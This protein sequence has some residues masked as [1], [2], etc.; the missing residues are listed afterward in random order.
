MKVKWQN[1]VFSGALQLTIF[2]TVIIAL[3][4]TG[5]VLLV[6][7]HLFFIEQSRS[8]IDTVQLADTG[9]ATLKQQE[10]ESIDTLSFA[11]AQV[12]E[13]QLI[14]THLSHWGVFEKAWVG[15]SHRNKEFIKC[16]LLGTVLASG[17]RPS[18]YLC[19]THKPLAVVGT[20]RIT[21][22]AFLPSLGIKTGSIAGHSYYGQVLIN[23]AIQSSGEALPELKHDYKRLL[24]FYLEEF[25]PENDRF[26]SLE[27][28]TMVINSFKEKVK[29]Y[30]SPKAVVLDNLTLKG[31]I[32]IRSDT[33]ITV[34]RTASL[35]DVLL[36][37]PT[38]IIEEGVRGNFQALAQTSIQTGKN[39]SLSYPSALILHTK[40]ENAP[41]GI[42]HNK[43]FV[44]EGSHIRGTVCFLADDGADQTYKPNIFI[45]ESAAVTGEIYCLGNTE[46][47]G[48][49]TGTVY[50]EHF[51]TNQGGTNYVNHLY[52]ATI[53]N[54]LPGAYGGLLFKNE[55]KTVMKWLY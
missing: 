45:A 10:N 15:S 17:Q 38:I 11:L 29:G 1:K 27:P 3:L 21:G 19:E 25:H 32:I 16:A 39:C 52:N 53:T 12:R 49:I 4:L 30:Y 6:Y 2:I 48:R 9:I 34:K 22:D 36:A 41:T 44:D 7:S 18:V 55:S 51:V 33:R 47:R 43:I 37:A 20:T 26:I 24:R 40:E 8:G 50:T 46:L 5:A 23:G 28:T 14:Q 31:N 42:H 35:C 13:E 54:S